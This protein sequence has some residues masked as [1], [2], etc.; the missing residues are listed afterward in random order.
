MPNRSQ[1][2]CW[3]RPHE[4][5]SVICSQDW[6]IVHYYVEQQTETAWFHWKGFSFH[7][8]P[9]VFRKYVTFDP[10]TLCARGRLH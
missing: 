9:V 1:T 2:I 3:V 10:H 6:S 8:L 7:S 5:I 4:N